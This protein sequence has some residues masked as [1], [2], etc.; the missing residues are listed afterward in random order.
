MP[1]LFINKNKTLAFHC[2][3]IQG[4]KENNDM[5]SSPTSDASREKREVLSSGTVD[6]KSLIQ[7][8]QGPPGPRGAPGPPV[9]SEITAS[10][11]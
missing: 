7:G 3:Y 1:Y 2:V 4:A 11:L 9:R 5:T 6:I 10:I 8:P